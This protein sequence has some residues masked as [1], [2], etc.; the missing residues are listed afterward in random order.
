MVQIIL[1]G[2]AVGSLS[3]EN[4][5]IYLT[6]TKAAIVSQTASTICVKG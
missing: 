5:R 1:N 4:A 2:V 6:Q 3:N